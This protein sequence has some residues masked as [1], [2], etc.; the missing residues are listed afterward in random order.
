MADEQGTTKRIIEG[1]WNCSSCAT[2]EIRGALKECPS[3]GNPRESGAEMKFEFG[4][5]NA[6]GSVKADT[7]SDQAAIQAAQAGADWFCAFCGTGNGNR[8]PTCG[9]CGADRTEKTPPLPPVKSSSS[10]D[11]A[12][13]R[14]GN[15]RKW[16]A[17]GLLLVV[18]GG[19]FWGSRKH[20]VQGNVISTHWERRVARET[21]TRG[22]QQAWRDEVRLRPARMPIAG[23]GEDPGAENL[24]DCVRKYRKTIQEACGVQNVCRDVS[25]SYACG[26]ERK[27]EV[28]DQGNGYAEETCHEVPKS[29][30][31]M[32][33]RCANETRYC[34]R[35]IDGDWCVF[36]TW[37]WVP[38]AEQVEQGETGPVRWPVVQ[39]GALDRLK[40][41]EIYEVKVSYPHGSQTKEYGLS[42][43]DEGAFSR[44]KQGDRVTVTYNNFGTVKAVQPAP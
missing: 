15:N 14:T 7:V 39:A 40:K 41:T 37:S 42:L 35:R 32:V 17:A 10:S 5:R 16:I 21:F 19:L 1:K 18:A 36:D 26:S 11:T 20:E 9:N 25:E 2:K 22:M 12:R 8:A 4:S 34:D 44:W 31:R 33:Q 6:D 24:R 28:K 13:P 38:Q 23:A 27:C 30:T 3:C 29:C 43:K